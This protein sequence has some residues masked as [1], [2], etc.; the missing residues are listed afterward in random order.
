MEIDP[1]KRHEAVTKDSWN[2]NILIASPS[3]QKSLEQFQIPKLRRQ[4]IIFI[5]IVLVTMR[6]RSWS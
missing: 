5:W 2:K 3:S 6:G 4:L 1:K